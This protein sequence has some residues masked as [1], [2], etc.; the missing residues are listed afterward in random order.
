MKLIIA[1]GRDFTNTELMVQTLQQLIEEGTLPQKPTLICGMARGADMTAHRLWSHYGMDIIEMPADWD[2]LGKRAGFAR[3][4][5]M[6]AI[7]DFLVAFWDG[8]S[9]GTK[10]MI[11]QMWKLR[12]P[13]VSIPY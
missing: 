3:N 4:A 13:F 11:D 7:A 10:H 1:G 5:E 12:K 9:K 6:A 8:K 2:R